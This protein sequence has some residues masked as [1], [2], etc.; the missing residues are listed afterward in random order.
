MFFD[1]VVKKMVKAFEKRCYY[2][3]GPGHLHSSVKSRTAPAG[4]TLASKYYALFKPLQSGGKG[5][6]T[7]SDFKHS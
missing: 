1:E 3:Y 6:S 7:S 4:M 2:L 5:G